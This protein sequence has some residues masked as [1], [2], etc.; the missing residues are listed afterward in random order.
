MSLKMKNTGIEIEISPELKEIIQESVKLYGLMCRYHE[1]DEGEDKT[2]GSPMLQAVNG[3]CDVIR[4]LSDKAGDNLCSLMINE[5]W[6]LAY[7]KKND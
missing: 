1:T 3:M 7:S 2:D 6:R 4:H 5:A